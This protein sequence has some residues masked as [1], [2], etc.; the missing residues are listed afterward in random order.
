MERMIDKLRFL[1]ERNLN[2]SKIM[3][4]KQSQPVCMLPVLSREWTEKSKHSFE[5]S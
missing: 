2:N 4:E 3:M 5:M 1:S